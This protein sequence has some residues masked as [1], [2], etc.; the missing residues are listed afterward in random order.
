MAIIQQPDAISMSGNMKKFIVSSGGQISFQLSDGGVVLLDAT[1]EPGVDG[2]ATID[3]KDIVES[4][5]SYL[6]SHDD[7][8]EQTSIVKS[9]TATI[10]G[11]VIT[12]KVI[13]SGVANLEDTTS[14]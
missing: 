1:Y 10:D 4:R 8:Y 2:R 13:R 6:I 7:F 3:V 12:F 5:L 14:N 11:T 9:F